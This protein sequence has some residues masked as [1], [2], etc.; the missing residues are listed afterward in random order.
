MGIS[1]IQHNMLMVNAGRHMNINTKKKASTAERLSSGYKI[2]RAADDAAGLSISEKMRYMIRGLKQGTENAMDGISWVQIGD[3]SLEEVHSMLHRM[4]ELAIKSSNGTNTDDDR[5]MM[6]AE[7]AHLQKEIDRLT[8]NTTFNEQNIFQEHEWPYHQIEGSTYW[9][10]AQYHTVREGENDL[11]IS[12]AINENDPLETVSIK[13]AAGT[14]TT[15]QLVDEIDTALEEAGLLEKGIRF[16][17]TDLGFCNL[18]LEGG[19]I[20][21]DVS[22]GLSYLLF[23]NFDGG[24]LG[25]LIGTTVYLNDG[26]F[27]E[28][29]KDVNDFITFEVLNAKAEKVTDVSITLAEGKYTK[30]ML[31]EQLDTALKD[32]LK[33]ALGED[34][35]CKVD[36]DHHGTGIMLSSPDFII[37]KFKGNMFEIDN[38]IRTGVFYDNVHHSNITLTP[39]VFRGGSVLYDTTTPGYDQGD[40]ERQ[41]FHIQKGVN[42]LLVINPNDQ[43][44]MVIDLTNIDGSGKSMDGCTMA[45]MKDELDKILR[46]KGVEVSLNYVNGGYEYDINGTR[47]QL[48]SRYAGLTFTTTDEGPGA[49]VGINKA[50]STAYDTLFTSRTV[51]SGYK[52]AEFG[53]NDGTLDENAWMRG[54]ADITGLKI[55]TGENDAFSI[56]ISNDAPV[57]IQVAAGTYDASTLATEIQNRLKDKG[58]GTDTISVSAYGNVIRMDAVKSEITKIRVGR[59]NRTGSTEANL[60]FRDIF[61]GT[62]YIPNTESKS[63][64]NPNVKIDLTPIGA[65]GKRHPNAA[66]INDDGTVYIDPNYSRLVVTIDGEDRVVD[67]STPGNVWASKEALAKHIT[68]SLKPIEK[69][70]GCSTYVIQ[71]GQTITNSVSKGTPTDG[72][73]VSYPSDSTYK[74]VVGRTKM[75]AGQGSSFAY[76]YNYGATVTFGKSLTAPIK[77]TNDNKRFAFTL[78]KNSAQTV[79]DLS[80]ELGKTEFSSAAEF[81]DALQTAIN[82]KLNKDPD[83]Y[84]G[85]K[86]SLN[87]NTLVLTAGLKSG[88]LEMSGRDDTKI[89]MDTSQGT[90]IWDLHKQELPASASLTGSTKGVNYSFKTQGE[91][92]IALKLTEP[93]K[94]A[95]NITIKLKKDYQYTSRADLLSDLNSSEKLGKYGIT[96]SISGNSLVFTTNKG[97]A[98]YKLDVTAGGT[99]EK[100]LFGY[101]QE[102]GS[103]TMDGSTP[104]KMR[105]NQSVQT[106]FTLSTAAERQFTINIDGTDVTKSL[107]AGPYN[108]AEDVAK[109]IQNAFGASVVKVTADSSGRLVFESAKKGAGHSISLSY[110]ADSAMKKIFGTKSLGGAEASISNAGTLTLTRI[111]GAANGYGTIYVTSHNNVDT[112]QGGSFIFEQRTDYADPYY[113]DGYHSG[114]NS[115]MDGVDLKLNANGKIE[116]NSW[117]NN[118]T[119]Y[120]ADDYVEDKDANGRVVRQRATPREINISLTPVDGG[121]SMDELKDILQQQIDAQTNNQRKLNVSVTKAG[122]RIEMADRGSKYRIFKNTDSVIY[123]L[124]GSTYKDLRPAG[125]FYEKVICST[126]TRKAVQNATNLDGKQNGHEVYAVGRQDVRNHEVRI[127]KG[128]N[129][130]L[131]L[132]FSTP[133]QTYT[134]QMVLDP[135][136]YRNETLAKQIQ[137]QLNK[138]LKENGLPEGLIEA[139]VGAVD[140]KVAGADDQNALAFRL[141]ETVKLPE[142]GGSAGNGRYGIEAIGGTAA[143]SVFYATDGDIARAYVRG[144]TD[145]SKGVEI[146]PGKNTFSVDVD[147]ERYEIELTPKKYTAQELIDHIN[148]LLEAD[149]VPLTALEEDG[150]LKLMHANYGKHK[151]NHLSGAVK[152]DLF[153][154]EKGEWAGKQP[155]RLR[156]SGVS[157]D[158]IEVDKPWMD[159]NSLGIN[160]LTIEKFKNAQKAITRLKKAVTK[161][162]EVRSYFG[163]LQNRL[164]STVRNNQNKIENTTAAE[165]RIRD[166]DFSKEAVENS[167]HNILEQAGTSMMT[168]IMQNSKLALQLLQ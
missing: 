143:F 18:N 92:T 21:D 60:G 73:V 8:D 89:T 142:V 80:K 45:E 48:P 44:E 147:G 77:I 166:A 163:A 129:D 51:V 2:N 25:A 145:I 22:G 134:L 35:E 99:A 102:D 159:T 158:W 108:T 36:V 101:P 88:T 37:T 121:Y 52:M 109:A 5:A 120:Y 162:S 10:P 58:Y 127:Q 132:E 11:V 67:V 141:S 125:S 15:K 118:M 7:F 39:G 112:Y 27:I 138:A 29:E 34:T 93:G 167:I 133:D 161:A 164:E 76:E 86:V 3:G 46:P 65:D 40:P 66:K 100:F 16:E 103:Y 4:T 156:V 97:G 152:N 165:S 68:D 74:N 153:F 140:T 104:Y 160:T 56:Q 119:F 57:T 115:Y 90:F 59:V 144:G 14:Y 64:Y 155:M 148:E 85:V 98:G 78:N 33:D 53:G 114:M 128:G 23:D 116:I 32:A 106:G 111:G 9:S 55:K 149:D 94:S 12:Y 84:G 123:S 110:K 69:D 95:Q 72:K 135:G 30:D 42:N 96:A 24:T 70:I 137:K 151:I 47:K 136:Y 82:K 71:S 150:R 54:K 13:V 87:G 124:N 43:G 50:K 154:S 41:V 62:D 17:Y 117:N 28:V 81:G 31:M 75:T 20:I 168:Q 61:Q 38:D 122:V 26:S 126:N 130:Q 113:E 63:G 107:A 146:K 1:S 19:K 83:Q 131:S 79:I 49:K 6:Q 139:V 105:T 91:P 157:G